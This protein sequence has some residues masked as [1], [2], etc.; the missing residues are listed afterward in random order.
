MRIAFCKI[1]KNQPQFASIMLYLQLHQHAAIL[2]AEYLRHQLSHPT[3]R[4]LLQAQVLAAK[5]YLFPPVAHCYRTP[6]K[7]HLDDQDTK[8]LDC[9]QYI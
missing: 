4:L 1:G 6:P 2:S 5:Y 3:C 7:E 8:H 9:S